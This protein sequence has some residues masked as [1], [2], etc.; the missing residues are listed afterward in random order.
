VYAAIQN[1]AGIIIQNEKNEVLLVRKIDQ[2][3]YAIPW[4]RVT[5]GQSLQECIVER[6]KDLTE[7]SVQP[8]FLGPS[9]HIEE[10]NHFI[11]FDHTASIDSK[12]HHYVREGLDY[13]WA[14]IEELVTVPMVPLTRQILEKFFLE[15]GMEAELSSEPQ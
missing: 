10:D 9:E 7:L 6:V 2:Y 1:F 3:A 14:G 4:C 11:S 15:H 8:V 12:E 5:P 13:L